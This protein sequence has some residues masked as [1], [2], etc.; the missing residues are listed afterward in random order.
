MA[1]SVYVEKLEGLKT[2][3]A[4]VV[5]RFRESEERPRAERNLRATVER[6]MSEAM[7]PGEKYSH[8]P[9]AEKQEVVDRCDRVRRWLNDQVAKQASVAKHETPIVF[10]RDIT[11]E[12]TDLTT[13]AASILNKPKP[14]PKAQETADT[15]MTDAKNEKKDDMDID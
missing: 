7:T 10:V 3:G 9:A 15:P 5:E 8:I 11:K 6:V 4:P 14:Q 2:I 1:K 13:Y 12:E